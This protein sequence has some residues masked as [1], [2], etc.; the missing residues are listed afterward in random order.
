MDKALKSSIL[1]SRQLVEVLEET[2]NLETTLYLASV[3]FA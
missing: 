2:R 1:L 3:Q